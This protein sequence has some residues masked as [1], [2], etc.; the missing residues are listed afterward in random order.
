M[1][2]R[3]QKRV[4]GPFNSFRAWEEDVSTEYCI[5]LFIVLVS[6]IISSGLA[7]LLLDAAVHI[8][9]GILEQISSHGKCPASAS[10]AIQLTIISSQSS[11]PAPNRANNRN[12]RAR[13]PA[14]GRSSP[15]N[16]FA[17]RA[18]GRSSPPPSSLPPSS[19]PA[20]FSDFPGDVANDL[21][22]EV[23]EERERG[24]DGQGLDGQDDESEMGEDLF[25]ADN[26][27]E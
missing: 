23:E 5:S 25:D 19:P 7:H 10:N 12:K 18:I 22:D 27:M 3:V 13:S 9:S 24:R 11:P 2:E 21:E 14:L 1:S 16:P 20:P 8:I 15:L 17:A 26:L 4:A 6:C